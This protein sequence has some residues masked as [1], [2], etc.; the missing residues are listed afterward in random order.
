MHVIKIPIL[1]YSK[2]ALSILQVAMT[3]M[4][5]IFMNL[6]V[7]E[8]AM[9]Q[10]DQMFQELLLF[11][12]HT[13]PSFGMSEAQIKYVFHVVP[14]MTSHLPCLIAQRTFDYLIDIN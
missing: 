6:V 2:P 7:M 8:S 5:G 11:I 4:C 1:S 13:L 12:I 9:I 14:T 10:I 3:T